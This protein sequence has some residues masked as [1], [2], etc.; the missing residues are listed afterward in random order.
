MLDLRW[1]VDGTNHF[2]TVDGQ[3]FVTFSLEVSKNFNTG[4]AMS[5]TTILNNPA[6]HV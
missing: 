3:A 5:Y 2:T 6:V 4:L 1:Y